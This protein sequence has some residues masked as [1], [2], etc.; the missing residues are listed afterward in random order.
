MVSINSIGSNVL[1]W[2]WL[3]DNNQHTIGAI[4]GQRSTEE[5]RGSGHISRRSDAVNPLSSQRQWESDGEHVPQLI[6]P[7]AVRWCWAT[8]CFTDVKSSKEHVNRHRLAPAHRGTLTHGT[9]THTH[10]LPL[11]SL[12]L[13]HIQTHLYTSLWRSHTPGWSP[14]PRRLEAGRRAGTLPCRHSRPLLLLLG[15]SPLCLTVCCEVCVSVRWE[16]GACAVLFPLSQLCCEPSTA[17]NFISQSNTTYTPPPPPPPPPP[18][19][20]FHLP[21]HSL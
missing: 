2:V 15:V 18:P 1:C 12:Q 19:S 9:H 13:L 10:T 16:R 8:L 21:S 7:W 5:D 3:K 6:R 20:L 11:L 14:A 17:H 4:T